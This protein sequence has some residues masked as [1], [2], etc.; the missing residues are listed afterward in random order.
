MV[1]GRAA[2]DDGSSIADSLATFGPDDLAVVCIFDGP[3]T[4]P[5]PAERQVYGVVIED[6]DERWMLLDEGSRADVP[7]SVP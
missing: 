2:V 7:L 1:A 6:P 3:F 4:E 5:R